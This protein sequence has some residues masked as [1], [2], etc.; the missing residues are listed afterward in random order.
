[1]IFSLD[2]LKLFSLS[3]V[4]TFFIHL[5]PIFVA[6]VYFAKIIL[7]WSKSHSNSLTYHESFFRFCIDFGIKIRSL[8]FFAECFCSFHCC[9]FLINFLFS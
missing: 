9:N 5:I 1:M 7:D 4:S 2:L 6:S 8:V 3:L